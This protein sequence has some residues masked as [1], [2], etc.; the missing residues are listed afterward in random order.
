MN[1]KFIPLPLASGKYFPMTNL[2]FALALNLCLYGFSHGESAA[3]VLTLH[4]AVDAEVSIDGSLDEAI[5]QN[6]LTSTDM[7]VLKPDTLA[8]PL[9]QTF[10]RLFY[11]D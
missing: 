4:K 2:V 9:F 6:R 7:T 1:K 10:T 5:W 8:V 3:A 11:T